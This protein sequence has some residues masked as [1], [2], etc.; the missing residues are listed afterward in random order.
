MV[1]APA[2]GAQSP[3]LVG[4]RVAD[5]DVRLHSPIRGGLQRR[6]EVGFIVRVEIAK[7]VVEDD[8]ATRGAILG[9]VDVLGLKAWVRF[10]VSCKQNT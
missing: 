7:N 10:V 3:R 6:K 8:V 9:P 2:C 5:G 4:F 1:A